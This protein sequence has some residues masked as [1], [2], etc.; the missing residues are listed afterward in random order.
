MNTKTAKASL[1]MYDFPE[2]RDATDA[3]WKGIAR[4][5][6]AEGL[7]DIPQHLTH[8]QPL[9]TL[10]SDPSLLFSQCCGY[11]VVHGYKDQLQVLATPCSVAPG[12]VGADYASVIVVPE[13]SQYEDVL[14]MSDTIAVINGA[15]SHSGMNALFGLVSSSSNAGKFFSQVRISGSHAASLAMVQKGE[16]DVASIDCITYALLQRYRPSALNTTRRL[17]FTYGA[18]T[19]PYVTRCD[20]DPTIVGRMQSALVSTFEDPSLASIKELLLLDGIEIQSMDTYQRI[21]SDF[22]HSLIA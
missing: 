22:K 4:H 1:P 7:K 21:I 3:L 11:D 14:E 5:F 6:E 15:E 20:I 9:K 16:A 13:H 18:P 17:G 2:V 8:G 10:W 19:P 12:C